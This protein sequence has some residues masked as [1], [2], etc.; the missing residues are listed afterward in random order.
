MNEH[1]NNIKKSVSGFT[2]RAYPECFAF[3]EML[4]ANQGN[5]SNFQTQNVREANNK[6]YLGHFPLQLEQ[7]APRTWALLNPHVALGPYSCCGWVCTNPMGFS[8]GKRPLKRELG[9]ECRVSSEVEGSAITQTISVWRPQIIPPELSLCLMNCFTLG[10]MRVAGPSNSESLQHSV[11]VSQLREM[12]LE[13]SQRQQ[14]AAP[15]P[16]HFPKNWEFFP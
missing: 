6:T 12:L 10:K 4:R 2:T 13:L 3:K 9:A 7:R 11:F 8:G 14:F 15:V 16:R 5:Y 1:L